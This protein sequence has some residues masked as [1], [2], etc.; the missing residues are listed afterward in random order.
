[1]PERMVRECG[2]LIYY[3]DGTGAVGITGLAHKLPFALHEMEAW[4]REEADRPV[5]SVWC[6]RLSGKS[7]RS[8]R[9]DGS[10]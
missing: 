7:D 1:M 3:A 2:F 9:S 5:E 6:W 8:D 4:L 10:D